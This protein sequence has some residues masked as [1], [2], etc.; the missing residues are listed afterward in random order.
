M[1]TVSDHSSLSWK[2]E[3]GA[4]SKAKDEKMPKRKLA[5]ETT[6]KL[7]KRYNAHQLVEEFLQL[8]TEK[9]RKAFIK[10]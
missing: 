3:F 10:I 4:T 2:I 7:I 9:R 8:R 6:T 1:D 5:E